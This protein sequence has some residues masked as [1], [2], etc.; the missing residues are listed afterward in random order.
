MGGHLQIVSKKSSSSLM[1]VFFPPASFTDLVV[2]SYLLER[3]NTNFGF[4]ADIR[5][6]TTR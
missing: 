4:Y 6:G 5:K 2:G 3:A 1:S